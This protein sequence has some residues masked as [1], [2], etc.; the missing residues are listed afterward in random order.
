MSD[1][2]NIYTYQR[3][4]ARVLGSR[5]RT[6]IRGG[7]WEKFTGVKYAAFFQGGILLASVF[8][9]FIGRALIL[10][11]LVPLAPA[12]I[13]AAARHYGLY[14]L[15]VLLF[16]MVGTSNVQ[17]GMQLW[18][19]LGAVLFIYLFIQA[20]PEKVA[21]RRAS[22]PLL[23]LA[24]IF[25]VKFVVI[26]LNEGSNFDYI[27]VVFEAIFAA[28]LTPAFIAA[29]PAAGKIKGI[30]PLSG[31][32]AIYLMLVLAGAVAGSGNIN[33]WELGIKEL[34]SRSLILLCALA[35]GPGMGA[36]SGA[37][38]GIIPGLA[39]AVTPAMVGAYSFSGVMAGLGRPL[40]KAGVILGYLTGNIIL[41]VF[42]NDYQGLA[43]ALAETMAA[44]VLFLLM[45]GK[46]VQKVIYSLSPEAGA[47]R[48]ETG[49]GLMQIMEYKIR[50]WAV[51]LREIAGA[52]GQ[53][54]SSEDSLSCT[55]GSSAAA[56][57]EEAPRMVCSECV[58]H[59]HCWE[60]KDSRMHRNIVETLEVMEAGRDPSGGQ[61]AKE[62]R[63]RCIKPGEM[64]IALSCL[65]G[66]YNVNRYWEKRLAT[67]KDIVRQQLLGV[68]DIIEKLSLEGDKGEYS[69]LNEDAELRKNLKQMGIHVMQLYSQ[70][71]CG[72][73]EIII[74]A[75]SCGGTM[76]C[77]YLA[78]PA[79]SE[80]L[81]HNY[82]AAGC[83]CDGNVIQEHCTYR[84]YQGTTFHV[85]GGVAG[86]NKGG[87]PVSGD[88]FSFLQLKG[89][90]L[91]ALLSDGMGSG[92]DAKEQS[93][94]TIL[95]LQR[96]LELGLEAESAIKTVN[97]VMMLRHPGDI[98]ATL[99]LLLIDLYSGQ[100]EI[101]KVA[102]PPTY[103]LRGGR[104]T[105]IRSSSLPVGILKEM[106]ITSTAKNLSSGD[107]LVVNTDG[108]AD[109]Y[110]N[111][112]ENEEW[113]PGVLQE[114]AGYDPKEIVQVVL[115]L[116][117]VSPDSGGAVGD[118]MTI[119]A[120]KLERRE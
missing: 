72:R 97:S 89:G 70:E 96:L 61:P 8:S 101:I 93:Q 30:K 81:G 31:E 32:E 104:V 46:W 20:L 60:Q 17:G 76:D 24:I 120:V 100:A 79:I 35:G 117:E 87:S 57:A 52:V 71:A 14:S 114:V 102:T 45:P 51:V 54:A 119:M 1:K 92:T 13:A 6:S 108:I 84:L 99:D 40:G 83:L 110:Q 65:L 15:P 50:Q 112:G 58:M 95:L 94:C 111:T 23:V 103:L 2:T 34:V 42:I 86:I 91:A 25:A 48:Q 55:P 107:V 64:F 4:T 33:I 10:G 80:L 69:F 29:F 7:L 43:M 105:A 109:A 68:S 115:N 67:G 27:N 53:V 39:Y 37:V 11:D 3:N 106:S 113:L 5:K 66:T 49:S 44:S 56:V 28:S 16:A 77:R 36:A 21:S 82:A 98:F 38:V 90:K 59:R 22:I 9:F 26:S 12:F 18:A 41:V 116:A 88:S 47:A 74:T 19:S 63:R 78:A 75:R 73:R 85:T 118:D 62:L